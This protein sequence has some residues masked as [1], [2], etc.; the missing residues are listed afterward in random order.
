MKY[1]LTDNTIKY[2]GRKLYRIQRLSDG[3]LG[4]YVES[5]KNLSQKNRCFIYNTSKVYDNAEVYGNTKV[6][7]NT[8]VY[9]N[10]EV[11]GNAEVGGY[12]EVF[13][14]IELYFQAKVFGHIKLFGNLYINY[15]PISIEGFRHTIT[16]LQDRAIIGCQSRTYEQW[17]KEGKLIGKMHGYLSDEIEHILSMLRVCKKIHK[18]N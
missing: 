5:E 1:K 18:D 17:F 10:A 15:S 11:Y 13:D 14:N 2:K 6:Y 16:C 3:L 4:G 9:D 7:D 8:E 12:A